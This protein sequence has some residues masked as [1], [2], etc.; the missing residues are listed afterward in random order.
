MVLLPLP[1]FH[2]HPSSF[3][4]RAIGSGPLCHKC[5]AQPSFAS[6]TSAVPF[7]R[8]KAAPDVSLSGLTAKPAPKKR[9]PARRKTA[10]LLAWENQKPTLQT[11]CINVSICNS[12]EVTSL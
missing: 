1:S 6:S 8:S 9:A 12:R 7:A 11:M 2:F 10:G 4:S 5:G 3:P